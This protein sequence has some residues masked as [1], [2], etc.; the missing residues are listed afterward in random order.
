M[1]EQ[2]GE[3]RPPKK[4]K[5][6]KGGPSPNPGG[7]RKS[8]SPATPP[9]EQPKPHTAESANTEGKRDTRFK[10]GNPGKAKG[11]RHRASRIAEQ[12][13]DNQGELLVQRAFEMAMGGEASVMRALLDR[14]C[15]PRRERPVSIDMPK[16][17]AA[18][19]LIAAA[20]ALTDAVSTGDLLPGEAAQLSQLIGNVAQA[21][22]V[23][24]NS[25][26]IAK[27]EALLE[28]KQ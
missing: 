7:K 8:P 12:L 1:S 20:A 4:P 26:R 13:I 27:L 11:T 14:L 18:A 9:P 17:G 25:E 5:W 6:T 16:I 3:A 2:S 22:E 23:A 19:D 28:A 10:A 21:I 15:P 24:Q